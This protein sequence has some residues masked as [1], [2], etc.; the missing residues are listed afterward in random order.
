VLQS[1]ENRGHEA[2][3]FVEKAV[4]EIKRR[5]SLGIT[6]SAGEQS[7]DVYR[8]WFDAGAHRYLL[9]VETTNE[10]LFKA[11]H[12]AGQTL[13]ARYDALDRLRAAGYQVGTG[14]MIGLP[15]QTVRDLANDL[16]FFRRG[17]FDMFG[18]GPYIPDIR[19]PLATPSVIDVWN[20]DR[21]R[22]FRLS[23]NMIAILRLMLPD[24]NIAAATALDAIDHHGREQGLMAGANVVMPV[25]TP[26]RY[27]ASYQL[28]PGK[29][30]IDEDALVCR[31]C[32][33]RRIINSG[34][35]ISWNEWGDSLHFKH[36][37]K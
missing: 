7:P 13:S 30:C 19:T 12:P 2:V 35:D 22:V 18:M 27:R 1:G 14:V 29:P 26:V 34:R 5:T 8:R 23:I 17:D 21:D 33:T 11:L 10:V 36:R 4:G 6:L 32:M 25:V 31:E 3:S 20:R 16:E 37:T 28:Y 9:R 15:G 24:V